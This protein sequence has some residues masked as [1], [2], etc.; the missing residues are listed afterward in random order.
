M[1]CSTRASARWL[2][3][4]PDESTNADAVRSMKKWD[5]WEQAPAAVRDFLLHSERKTLSVAEFEAMNPRVFCIM[6][7]ELDMVPTVRQK[8][9]ELGITPHVLLPHFRNTLGGD[10]GRQGRSQHGDPL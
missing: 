5:V 3:C 1:I 8:I 9:A 6:P 10:P 2:H 4:M 7:A